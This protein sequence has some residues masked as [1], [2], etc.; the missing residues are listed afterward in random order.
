MLL[1]VQSV[2]AAK[3]YYEYIY[4]MSM[5]KYILVIILTAFLCGVITSWALADSKGGY[6]QM[7]G[8]DLRAVFHE[9]TMVGEYR[10][11]RNMTQT[12]NYTEFHDEDGTTDYIEGQY[13]EDGI[14]NIVG[15][16]KIC[17]RYPGSDYY[18]RVYCFFVYRLDKC[19]YK[20][21]LS[22]MTVKGPRSWD[23]W[24]SRA[25]RKGAGGTCGE[26]I[27]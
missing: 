23:L 4:N 8:D 11:F 1:F 16:D 24:T 18:N 9:T 3:I 13:R 20:Y 26:P 7:K 21:S 22:A 12:F 14:W 25:I 10:N 6:Q 17:Y 2:F 19:Y 15:E 27:G 5:S